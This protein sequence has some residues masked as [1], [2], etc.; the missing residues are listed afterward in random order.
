MSFVIALS[1]ALAD[2][3]PNAE[4]IP[5]SIQESAFS[6]E[7]SRGTEFVVCLEVQGTKPSQDLMARLAHD[8]A[9]VVDASEC[10]PVM[11]TRKG[12]GSY[13]KPTGRSAIFFRL[14]EL[15]KTDASHAT[16]AF[17]S[18]HDGKYAEDAT[19]FLELEGG[20][21]VVVKRRSNSMS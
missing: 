14:R 17:D 13:H 2:A 16:I 7:I 10:E 1:L 6:Y 18:Y 21:W 12:K 20:K 19:L 15:H 4:A 3:S 9:T 11:D 5:E 8:G